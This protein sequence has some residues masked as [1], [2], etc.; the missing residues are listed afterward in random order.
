MGA[1]DDAAM[2][3]TTL[4]SSSTA[5]EAPTQGTTPLPVLD[6][7]VRARAL[8]VPRLDP[9]AYLAIDD[10]GDITVIPL[11]GDLV[12]LGRSFSADLRLENPT[13]SRRHAVLSR[14]E[15]GWVLLDDR[16][17]NGCWVNGERVT[18]ALLRDRDRIMLGAVAMSFVLRGEPEA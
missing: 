18:R 12:R 14:E 17:A 4:E 10:G 16:S 7:A 6:H 8:H 15:A 9:G 2:H 11:E 1:P 13:V 5:A 3:A